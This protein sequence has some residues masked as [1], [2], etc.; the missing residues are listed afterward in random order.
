MVSARWEDEPG[1][2]SRTALTMEG[3]S[4]L[5]KGSCTFLFLEGGVPVGA[6]LVALVVTERVCRRSPA[7]LPELLARLFFLGGI[8]CG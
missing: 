1:N 5:V 4:S 3:I 7:F 6:V 2:A 8:P